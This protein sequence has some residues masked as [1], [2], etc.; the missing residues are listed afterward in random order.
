[1]VDQGS[2]DDEQDFPS[3]F[4]G[5]VI[6]GRYRLDGMIGKGG[7][8]SVWSTMHLGLGQRV[9]VKLIAKRYAGS[10]EARQR[11]DLEAKAVAQLKSRYVVQV[12]DN[13]ETEDGT[14]YIVMEL[15]D[16]ESL[17]HRIER[18]G[19]IPLDQAVRILGQVGRALT[20]AHGLG[21]IHRDLKPENI[22]LT[23]SDEDDDGEIA[24]VL[25]FGIA[26]IKTADTTSSATR[27]GTVLGTPLFM[28]P[29]QARGLKSVDHRTDLYSLGMVA[30]TML[31]GRNAYSGES[32][33]DILVAICTQPLPSLRTYAP[34]LPPALDA[35]MQRVCAKEP[36]DRFAAV[37]PMMEALYAAAGIAR[38]RMQSADRSATN[39]ASQVR[40]SGVRSGSSG[41]GVPATHIMTQASSGGMSDHRSS[42]GSDRRAPPAIADHNTTAAVSVTGA[43]IPKRSL[44][45]PAALIGLAALVLGGVGAFLVLGSPGESKHA[46]KGEGGAPTLATSALAVAPSAGNVVPAAP[47]S[48][49]EP[50]KAGD[51]AAPS[52][53]KP[54]AAAK[55]APLPPPPAAAV[56]PPEPAKTIPPPAPAPRPSN[57]RPKT[58]DLGF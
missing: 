47:K 25:D 15:L 3:T 35:W 16:G 18:R 54:V 4:P 22:F 14:P 31:T 6:A 7:M 30:F 9:A 56:H 36:A 45:M 49:A 40:G 33:G 57:P 58:P 2:G 53:A 51:S 27:T 55:P 37:E 44:A 46:S 48:S 23:R 11:F 1:M 13:G 41:G 20:R 32:F 38:P 10:R 39:Q 28:S 50:A 42:S 21:I 5:T 29:E 34:M 26:K 8:G 17:D 19:P 24:K 43:D 12:F 52:A